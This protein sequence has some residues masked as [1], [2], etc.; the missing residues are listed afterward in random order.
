[1]TRAGTA[2]ISTACLCWVGLSWSVSYPT[3]LRCWQCVAN[4][5]RPA[6]RLA[7][8][9]RLDLPDDRWATL[10]HPTACV[11]AGSIL[12]P[13][14]M[15][16]AG[17]VVTT[18]LR[19]GVHV[20]AMPHVLIT[21]DD[22]IAD[23][24]TFAGGASRRQRHRR[25]VRIPR[26]GLVGAGDAFDR[27]GRGRRHGIGGAPGHSRRGSLGGVPTE[28][29]VGKEFLIDIPPVD[30]PAQHDYRGMAHADVSPEWSPVN[31]AAQRVP[32]RRPRRGYVKMAC[33]FGLSAAGSRSV[34][35]R[36]SSLEATFSREIIQQRRSKALPQ[37][38][39]PCSSTERACLAL[40]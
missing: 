29:Y 28:G 36:I 2:P 39:Y 32:G 21:H 24:V 18:P 31:K 16:L 37:Q 7:V 9:R 11:P 10:V 3:T 23:G 4:A 5:R 38:F 19:I 35:A 30:L 22:K 26:A 33:P 40:L 6:G 15:L 25:R 13:G 27:C 12:G 20:V 17:A 34:D 8:V 14:T 1:M